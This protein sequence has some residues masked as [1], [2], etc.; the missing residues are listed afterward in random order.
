MISSFNVIV[1]SPSASKSGVIGPD[2]NP[3]NATFIYTIHNPL[4][5]KNN[6]KINADSKNSYEDLKRKN[7]LLQGY[8]NSNTDILEYFDNS[9]TDSSVVKSLKMTSKGFYSYSKVLDDKTIDKLVSI[10]EEKIKES[11]N[12]ILNAKFDINPKRIG[13]KD[14]GCEFCKFK[15]I[16]FKTEKDVVNLKEYKNLEFLEGEESG[17]D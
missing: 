11:T 17:M 15:D 16:C 10:T 6:I 14:L 4:Y 1:K 7:L 13:G 8:S 9:Y 2:I 12:D 3:I 5:G